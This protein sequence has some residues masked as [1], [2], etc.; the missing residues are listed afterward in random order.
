MN[1]KIYGHPYHSLD[2]YF[3]TEEELILLFTKYTIQNALDYIDGS[4]AIN[5]IYDDKEIWITDYYGI[6][7]IFYNP[8]EKK[9]YVN[10]TKDM[11]LEVEPKYID[12]CKKN[13]DEGDHMSNLPIDKYRCLEIYDMVLLFQKQSWIQ[14]FN[15]YLLTVWKNWFILPPGSICIID[16]HNMYIEKYQ[17]NLDFYTDRI[18]PD[19]IFI[20]TIKN[21]CMY[22]KVLCPLTAGWDTRG[23]LS[24]ITKYAKTYDRYTFFGYEEEIAC[25]FNL[26][27]V[28]KNY[29]GPYE[30]ILNEH[31]TDMNGMAF[32]CYEPH[33]FEQQHIFSNY[34]IVY[35]GTYA[36]E[37]LGCLPFLM[38]Q[39]KY[40]TGLGHY[41]KTET[42]YTKF[43][44]PYLQKRLLSIFEKRKWKN[45][46][47]YESDKYKNLM[48]EKVMK[49]TN[50]SFLKIP[51]D[52]P[53]TPLQNKRKNRD[54][55]PWLSTAKYPG[56]NLKMYY[57]KKYIKYMIGVDI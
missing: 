18:E 7:P 22:N 41:F 3:Y 45:V 14:K 30:K 23:I 33:H 19:D 36:N 10:F 43:M 6:Y 27:N 8:I 21:T 48:L 39:Y 25:L 47:I 15:R 38:W 2:Y 12:L 31:I 16:K 26:P 42:R 55:V 29:I 24:V 5:I 35:S 52:M 9:V 44:P 11:Y 28:V 37:F 54:L 20:T 40:G 53:Y 4:F 50:D 56:F 51:F 32:L 46:H 13:I 57:V 17:H 49:K 1:I 34:D